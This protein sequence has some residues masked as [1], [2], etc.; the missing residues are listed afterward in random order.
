MPPCIVWMC[1][2][3]A[4]NL[5]LSLVQQFIPCCIPA[6]LPR[7]R[8]CLPVVIRSSTNQ[9]LQQRVICSCRCSCCLC[10]SSFSGLHLVYSV[11]NCRF[12]NFFSANL[13]QLVLVPS[14]CWS[15]LG[16]DD[17]AHRSCS[18][19]KASVIVIAFGLLRSY[20]TSV[21]HI[22]HRLCYILVAYSMCS[23]LICACLP[24]YYFC[25]HHAYLAGYRV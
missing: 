7:S 22:L 19:P 9:V 21:T 8:C 16:P 14:S 4:C 5:P 6:T 17:R 15:L 1:I 23:C 3:S 10:L 20:P 24:L 18:S 12:T 13:S 11:P 2:V 25:Y